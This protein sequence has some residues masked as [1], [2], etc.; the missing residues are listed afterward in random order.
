MLAAV[1]SLN[2][3]L[4]SKLVVST[5]HFSTKLWEDRVYVVK[6]LKLS[7]NNLN[8]SYIFIVF[9]VKFCF[10]CQLTSSNDSL[11]ANVG[12]IDL[13]GEVPDSLVGVFVGVRMDV[14]PAAWQL[15]CMGGI[16]SI[17][18]AG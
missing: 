10:Y 2:I 14:G 15:D 13:F 3:E 5:G 16:K 9:G 1:L 7:F 17:N 11:Y 4:I 12:S 18:G 6:V 8:S